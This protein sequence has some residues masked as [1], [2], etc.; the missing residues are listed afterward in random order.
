MDAGIDASERIR[1]LLAAALDGTLSD[2]QAEEL[3]GV[4]RDLLKLAWL[5]VAK[6]IAEQDQRIAELRAKL[7]GPPK[8]DPATPSGRRPVYAKPP[9]P[10]RKG[11]PG[12]R[13]GHA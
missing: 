7:D 5:A 13:K 11:R 1:E 2:A 8:L 6:R 10:K 4:D 12:A 9:A 3:A